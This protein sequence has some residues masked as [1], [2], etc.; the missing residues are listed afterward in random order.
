[1]SE[2]S[3]AERC[4]VA[5]ITGGTRGIGLAVAKRLTAD[6][7]DVL[8]TYKGDA[9][10]AEA[11][12]DELTGSGRRIEAIA[13]D[14]STADGA[15]AAIEA[16]MQRL[17]S[18]DVLVNNAGITRD[19]LL[20]R[21]NEDDWDDVLTTNLKGAFLTSKAA[22]RPMLR[23]RSGRIVNISSV[24]GQ[25]GNAGQANYAAAKAGLIGFTKSLAK[26]VGS[27][28]ITVNAIAPGFIATRMTDGLPVEAKATILE[29]TPLGRFGSPEDVAGAVAFLVG[30][31]AS[32][33]TGHTL[34]VDGGLFMP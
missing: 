8:L 1:M 34:T 31:D 12:T 4:G 20:M 33:I 18:L 2:A 17:G 5:V 19:T 27:R 32:F 22:I 10:A 3:D 21:M 13:A 30:P 14:I 16:A 7:Y 9:D 23:Q 24:V 25:V 28:G 26:E 11:A 15:G 29:R 6:G